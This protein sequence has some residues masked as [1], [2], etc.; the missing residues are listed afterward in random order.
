M[1]HHSYVNARINNLTFIFLVT[2]A[3]QQIQVDYYLDILTKA[4]LRIN[5]LWENSDKAILHLLGYV[6]G[7]FEG[8]GDVLRLDTVSSTD[9][10]N[11]KEILKFK[12]ENTT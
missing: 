9:T 6:P 8:A 5:E 4:L 3:T 1:L 12:Q 10:S 11:N 7:I 2:R